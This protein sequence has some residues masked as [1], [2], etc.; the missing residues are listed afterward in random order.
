M[1]EENRWRPKAPREQLIKRAAIL[2][3]IRRFFADKQ[4]L[5]VETPLLSQATVP[6]PALE[7]ITASIR[8]PRSSKTLTYY[9]QTSPEYAMKRLLAAG[10]GSI[11]QMSKAFRQDEWGRLHNPEFTLLEWYRLDFDHHALM[12][13]VDELL[14][15]LLQTL[16]AERYS[17]LEAFERVL[18][19]NPHE[20]EENE[21]EDCAR[22][23]EGIQINGQLSRDG[24][25][26]LLMSHCLEPELG[27]DRPTFIYD[28]P[29][30]QAALARIRPGK[31]PL[32][33]RFE[34]YYRG[35]E[36]GNGFH[37]LKASDEQRARFLNDLESRRNQG[38]E[39]VPLDERL[40]AALDHGLPDCAGVAMGVD[41]LI[42][43]A[44]GCERI[45]EVM[46]FTFEQA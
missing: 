27:K 24:W 33:S 6:D 39:T 28:F 3:K 1:R 7:S 43:L 32:A 5:E 46:S 45:E 19:L 38:L 37:E 12:T 9:L 4:V 41:R 23:Q 42:M 10:S 18:G 26:H 8:D 36:L 13:E 17:Y 14:Q 29:V 15:T 2:A 40:L 21:L 44:L 16:P 35:I 11:Y 22:R 34:V 31:P 20:A 25:L 30:S